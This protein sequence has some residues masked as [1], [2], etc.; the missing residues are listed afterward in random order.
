KVTYTIDGRR[1]RPGNEA[2]FR[3]KP[4][5]VKTIVFTNL[6]EQPVVTIV[7]CA[8]YDVPYSTTFVIKAEI[9][10]NGASPLGSDRRGC[11]V[12]VDIDW[13]GCGTTAGSADL[14]S[15]EEI[16]LGKLD[17]GEMNTVAWTF[18]CTGG[19]DVCFDIETNFGGYDECIV[20]QLVPP[21]LLLEVICPCEVCTYCDNEFPVDVCVTNLGDCPIED[22]EVE[23]AEKMGC[24][25]SS[26][27]LSD[28]T[29]TWKVTSPGLVHSTSQA[30]S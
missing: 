3:V 1:T 19:G 5:E 26:Q 12:W 10:N 7:E 20:H 22:F 23:I 21:A 25:S 18:H 27:R 14:E 6:R 28:V 11:G 9:T 24:A 13:V 2:C 4:C 16:H 8:D 30:T 17:P 29:Q 15:R